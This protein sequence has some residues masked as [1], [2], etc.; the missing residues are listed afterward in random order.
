MRERGW[1]LNGRRGGG[2]GIN[3][4]GTWDGRGRGLLGWWRGGGGGERSK[5]SMMDLLRPHWKIEVETG[6]PSLKVR[7]GSAT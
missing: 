7:L 5:K 6:L 1:R 3:R 4:D 2:E